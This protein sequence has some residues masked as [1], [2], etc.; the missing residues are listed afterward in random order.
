MNRTTLALLAAVTVL[1]GAAVALNVTTVPLIEDDEERSAAAEEPDGARAGDGSSDRGDGADDASDTAEDEIAP[2]SPLAA[3]ADPRVEAPPPGASPMDM[4]EGLL[5]PAPDDLRRVDPDVGLDQA[6]RQHP[7][8]PDHE[9]PE[10]PG[11]PE[12]GPAEAALSRLVQAHGILTEVQTA[13]G[14]GDPVARELVPYAATQL[15]EQ[16]E[17]AGPTFT[18]ASDVQSIEEE[19][20][21][22]VSGEATPVED[23]DPYQQEVDRL[24]R[25]IGLP[26][27][28][29]DPGDHDPED[30]A[31]IVHATADVV[32]A[33]HQAQRAADNVDRLEEDL[34]RV[35]TA[36]A[37][38]ALTEDEAKLVVDVAG[39]V[40][41]FT[42]AP[43]QA[44]LDALQTLHATSQQLGPS[45]AANAGDDPVTA[46]AGQVD[47]P[48][49]AGDVLDALVTPQAGHG[50]AGDEANQTRRDAEDL[51]DQATNDTREAVEEANRTLRDQLDGTREV[52]NE[53]IEPVEDEL[54]NNFV[55]P[56][57]AIVIL[58]EGD[59]EVNGTGSPVPV[60]VPE[61]GP[62][63]SLFPRAPLLVVDRGGDD[64]YEQVPRTT[65]ADEAVQGTGEPLVNE[66]ELPVDG[67]ETIDTVPE[68]GPTG[69]IVGGFKL[70][71]SFLYE[72]GTQVAES[73]QGV[74]VAVTADTPAQVVVDLAGDDAYTGETGAAYA[75][76]GGTAAVYDQAGND[77]YDVDKGVGLTEEDGLA[78]VDDRGG[79]DEVAVRR[80]VG[81]T[82][83]PFTVTDQGQV[84]F[85]DDVRYRLG[86]LGAYVNHA[87]ENTYEVGQA[88]VG[89]DLH[90]ATPGIH[91]LPLTVPVA[92][93]LEGSAEGFEPKL[94]DTDIDP[95]AEVERDGGDYLRTWI[96]YQEGDG[97][98]VASQEEEAGA[99]FRFC[100]LGVGGGGPQVC[101]P[102]ELDGTRLRIN[103]ADRS[104]EAD[105]GEPSEGTLQVEDHNVTVKTAPWLF[106]SL[107][108]TSV[109]LHN[110]VLVHLDDEERS[111]EPPYPMLLV[112]AGDTS[113]TYRSVEPASMAANTTSGFQECVGDQSVFS[114]VNCNL[115]AA[116]APN[117]V[118]D[119][120]GD[121][122]YLDGTAHLNTTRLADELGHE[123]ALNRFPGA[124]SVVSDLGGDDNFE[125]DVASV[126]LN[127][128]LQASAMTSLVHTA[129]GADTFEGGQVAGVDVSHVG[130]LNFASDT[131]GPKVTSLLLAGGEDGDRRDVDVEAGS[132][133]G[134]IVDEPGPREDARV[135]ASTDVLAGAVM[136][137]PADY[138]APDHSFGSVAWCEEGQRCPPVPATTA[139][140]VSTLPR[141]AGL[142]V[143]S[144]GQD[145]Y[146][147][148]DPTAVG[149]ATVREEDACTDLVFDNLLGAQTEALPEIVTRFVD[150]GGPDEYRMTDR[151]EP[152]P[153]WR[154]DDDWRP[155]DCPGN[156][157]AVP[158]TDINTTSTTQ[159]H[160]LDA[161]YPRHV[162]TLAIDNLGQYA[163]GL[164]GSSAADAAE[165]VGFDL[166]P[167]KLCSGPFA[168]AER[169]STLRGFE[170]EQTRCADAQEPN[171]LSDAPVD[172]GER[173]LATTQTRSTVPANAF[174][175]VNP[176]DTGQT[177][178]RTLDLDAR[179]TNEPRGDPLAQ[180]TSGCWALLEV[181]KEDRG[182]ETSPLWDRF[183]PDGSGWLP[184][185]AGPVECGYTDEDSSP[186]KCATD[187]FP[188]PYHVDGSDGRDLE[189]WMLPEG[190]YDYR[191]TFNGP[192]S[193]ALGDGSTVTG[194]VE[195]DREP[196][197]EAGEVPGH[198]VDV[199]TTQQ[200]GLLRWVEDGNVTEQAPGALEALKVRV[201][202]QSDTGQPQQLQVWSPLALG[203]DL[204]LLPAACVDGTLYRGDRSD[205]SDTWIGD[206]GHWVTTYPAEPWTAEDA[207]APPTTCEGEGE[208]TLDEVG[209]HPADASLWYVPHGDDPQRV[210][211]PA[212]TLADRAVVDDQAPHVDVTPV[213]GPDGQP[214]PEVDADTLGTPGIGV[215]DLDAP[216][217]EGTMSQSDL[218]TPMYIEVPFNVTSDSPISTV[219]LADQDDD[220]LQ[221][222]TITGN[223]SG[224]RGLVLTWS[225]DAGP[226]RQACSPQDASQGDVT[227]EARVNLTRSGQA[228][229]GTWYRTTALNLTLY[230]SNVDTDRRQALADALRNATRGAQEI[231]L[232]VDGGVVA[233]DEA[234]NRLDR[235]LGAFRLDLDRPRDLAFPCGADGLNLVTR[236]ETVTVRTFLDADDIE[237][238][239]VDRVTDEGTVPE[240]WIPVDDLR[241]AN[242]DCEEESRGEW[243]VFDYTV[244]DA[245]ENETVRHQLRTVPVDEA[246]NRENDFGPF[247]FAVVVDQQAP[248][249]TVEQTRATPDAATVNVTADEPFT[250]DPDVALVGPDGE[251]RAPLVT[252]TE[253]ARAHELPFEALDVNTTYEL[254]VEGT[255]EAGNVATAS[256]TVQTAR[257][258]NVSLAETPDVAGDHVDVTVAA[259][260]AGPQD[261]GDPVA[262]LEGTVLADGEPCTSRS[263]PTFVDAPLDEPSLHNL[264][265]PL[266]QCP[267]GELALELAVENGPDDDPLER[268]TLDANLV[269]DTEAPTPTLDVTGERSDTG[270]YTSAV[271]IEPAGEDDSRIAEA[272]LLT[273]DG[274]VARTTLDS[275][276]VHELTVRVE[277]AAGRT[278]T[279]TLTVPIDLDAPAVDLTSRDPLPTERSV[280]TVQVDGADDASGLDALRTLEADGSFGEWSPVTEGMQLKLDVRGLDEVV[281]E[282]RDRAGHVT[283]DVL[284][285]TTLVDAPRVED[286]DVAAA[287]PGSIEV[288]ATIDRELPLTAIAEQE[289]SVVAEATSEAGLD[290][291]L[292]LEGLTP[293]STA[294]VTVRAELSDGSTATLD[295]LSRTVTLPASQ[296]PPTVPENLSADPLDDGT[297]KLSWDP[298]Q[299][300]A[301]IDRY[302]VEHRAGETVAE[303]S[304]VTGTTFLDDPTPGRVHEYRVQALSLAG[305][306]SSWSQT[307][308]ASPDAPLEIVSY[309]ITPE[310]ASAGDPVEITVVAEGD[311][312]PATAAVTVGEDRI[313]LA[314]ESSDDGRWTYSAEVTLPTT[315]T[316]FPKGIEVHLGNQT[317]PKEG[318]FPGPVVKALQ[319]GEV[320]STDDVP[321]PGPLI[322]LLAAGLAATRRRWSA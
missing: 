269:H 54:A 71:A 182:G 172:S 106:D 250:L 208:G 65:A 156:Q 27:V 306:A 164:A 145:T 309:E 175:A 237:G 116:L 176:C 221:E 60:S 312:A 318:T 275:A 130:E 240:R 47:D 83:Q 162:D 82:L 62:V 126:D 151:T 17:Q 8:F 131:V 226:V 165:A 255:D 105:L 2:G 70:F 251:E 26:T 64:T 113:D 181:N 13:A 209:A 163:L 159:E 277:D 280:I 257:T 183:A 38:G 173:L 119:T 291:R 76:G 227:C 18:A 16:A 78:L 178:D 7:A 75:A 207:I 98:P 310:V 243:R 149:D 300:D 24:Y 213:P 100:V 6:L 85:D 285:V 305:Q 28:E 216:R 314:L 313:P 256:T 5:G 320:S 229:D 109:D 1:G 177:G 30:L 266:A 155:F 289:G 87:G 102:P 167:P 283:Q 307:V 315:D 284:P 90:Q 9:A 218:R 120:R 153:E 41:D 161:A 121:D 271:Q 81:S 236:E 204:D 39:M 44:R 150:V 246:G 262:R 195:I 79:D 287:S 293:A 222:N 51:A 86:G 72:S 92:L 88:G 154:N 66:D 125:G 253:E 21:L 278:A 68:A 174:G 43:L 238:L 297:V 225:T 94:L 118:L 124:G 272:E 194:T 31:R 170:T 171:R 268:V 96:Y 84:R 138:R 299:H 270:W 198:A 322:A 180:G 132:M 52:V 140:T 10:T 203:G 210:D 302:L 189:R 147:L 199:E 42:V 298:A 117:L 73:Q 206:R 63:G 292:E 108:D 187:A 186:I 22:R 158:L 25:A 103:A 101:V 235:D 247:E 111:Y 265:L 95:N 123:E 115:D 58:G 319:D 57:G 185:M 168:V 286:G 273:G 245:A 296:G 143:G 276:G 50:D 69:D 137:G 202:A 228:A 80:G 311:D 4:T 232:E 214:L 264:T 166:E 93:D 321:G 304:S 104:Y 35:D 3:G 37:D 148:E 254:V 184:V 282:V 196:M 290:H 219:T 274:P 14:Q 248:S 241:E 223:E 157:Y 220:P 107:L 67:Q 146:E 259:G 141:L 49:T 317:F 110:E 33:T 217:I 234:G 212:D 252:P 142:F 11:V 294:D 15:A 99:R 97:A 12:D 114:N 29:A 45:L 160:P 316:F 56:L 135:L 144:N 301:G 231:D 34:A 127:M 32:E 122:T 211:L 215:A 261:G 191:L 112:D 197:R 192:I 279:D 59:D 53:T 249:L 46:A 263:V 77:T 239:F 288:R 20:E 40:H 200:Q 267:A 205:A 244:R 260:A 193:A 190:T 89:V 23:V 134:V 179:E 303:V 308:E 230:P 152:L 258:L 295:D 74:E 129:G 48:A 133:G 55:D 136:G 242:R 233:E 281:A 91:G 169:G 61:V 139:S 224:E 19:S 128:T 36:L 188:V 201:A